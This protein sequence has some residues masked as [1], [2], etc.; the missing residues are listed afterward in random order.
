MRKAEQQI[1]VNGQRLPVKSAV[2]DGYGQTLQVGDTVIISHESDW[3]VVQDGWTRDMHDHNGHTAEIESV[4]DDQTATAGCITL[5]C[6][7]NASR[8]LV[9]LRCCE[10]LKMLSK[11][12]RFIP[13][14]T[15][16]L[17]HLIEQYHSLDVSYLPA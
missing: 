1:R 7:G 16:R 15:Q 12:T 9:R 5:Y 13:Q 10:G 17:T 2:M 11:F 8:N 6:H 14:G 3:P 4:F